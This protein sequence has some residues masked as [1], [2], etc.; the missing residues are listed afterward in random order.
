M[1]GSIG[2]TVTAAGVSDTSD[3]A[4]WVRRSNGAGQFQCTGP[5]RPAGKSFSFG[6]RHGR[7]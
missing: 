2:V 4:S 3:V 6:I 5:C 1:L 7:H